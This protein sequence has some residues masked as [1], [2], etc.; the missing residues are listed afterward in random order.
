MTLIVWIISLAA[1]AWLITVAVFDIR[2]R[3]VPSPY[4]TGIPLLLA[5]VIR[6]LSG[7]AALMAAVAVVVVVISERRHLKQKL[8]ET[9]VLVAG[10]LVIVWIFFLADIPTQSGI[11]GVVLFW[12]SWELRYIGGADAMTLITCVLLWPNIEFLLAY[13]IAGIAWSLGARIKQGGWLKFHPVPGL[14]V[15]ATAGILYLMYQV[16]LAIKI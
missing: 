5:V 11:A 9:L 12:V 1:L 7:T 3:Q 6:V 14:A 10:V 13:L 2:T 16:Y 4:W 15:I 8:L